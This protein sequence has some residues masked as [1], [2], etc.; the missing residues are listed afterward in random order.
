LRH[1]LQQQGIGERDVY[2]HLTTDGLVIFKERIYLL[3]NSELKKLIL[4]ELNVK[5]YSGHLGYQKTLITMKTFY[6][7]LDLKKEVAEFGARFLD[8]QQVK[9]E[10]NLPGGL[11]QPIWIPKWK[12]EVISM[13]FIT[14]LPSTTRQH[15]S[16]MVVVDRM[17][18]VAHFIMLKPTN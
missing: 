9:E 3:D 1:K 6:Y 5:I 8:F 18:M 13:E 17:T 4:R 2:Y 14:I 15:N 7:W 16:I 11:L 10:C 12:W